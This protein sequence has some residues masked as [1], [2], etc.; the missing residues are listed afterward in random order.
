MNLTPDQVHGLGIALNEATL[1]GVEVDEDRKVAAATFSVLTLPEQGNPPEDARVQ[2]VFS[3][4]GRIAVS[5]R[6]GR[7]NDT[8]AEVVKLS[9]EELLSAVQ[10]FGGSPIYGWEFFDVHDKN[11]P[12]WSDRLSLDWRN[13]GDGLAHSITLFQE[14]KDR[15]IDICLWFDSFVMRDARGRELSLDDFIAGG[16]RW[17]DA[18]YRGD[19]RTSEQG[20]FPLKIDA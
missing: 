18:L 4:V 17:W 5:L 14:G 8:T 6:L 9:V 19:S 1:W 16:K 10:S 2:F 20:I 12:R 3:P 13:G 11:F 15:H 7:W